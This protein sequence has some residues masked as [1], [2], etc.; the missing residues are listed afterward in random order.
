MKLT[1][2]LIAI[3][4][5]AFVIPVLTVQDYNA[6]LDDYGFSADNLVA[7]PWTIVTSIFIHADIVHLLSNILV[8]FF[9]GAAVEKEMGILKILGIFFLGAFLGDLLSLF[10]YSPSTVSIGASAGIFALVGLGMLIRPFDFSFYPLVV[11]IPLA[12]LGLIYAV[13]NIYGFI[14]GEGNISYIAHFGGLITGLYFGFRQEGI[15]KGM[16]IILI[17]A[18][19]MVIIPVAWWLLAR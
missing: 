8:L 18:L 2:A 3:M 5:I 1:L 7:K 4:V 13:Y 15:K 9:F 10:V 12:L 6:F 17:M 19:I 11:P 16:K 14:L